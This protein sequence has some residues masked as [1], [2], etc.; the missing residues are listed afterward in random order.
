[1]GYNRIIAQLLLTLILLTFFSLLVAF[2]LVGHPSSCSEG[3]PA[4]PKHLAPLPPPGVGE[5]ARLAHIPALAVE[6]T[7][8]GQR[9]LQHF[10]TS[11]ACLL[12]LSWGG[13]S[14]YL[15]GWVMLHQSTIHVYPLAHLPAAPSTEVDGR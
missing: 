2:V 7:F 6:G 8:G 5:A 9:H 3:Q 14:G 10:T 1:M 15:V 11:P 12:T 13:G 4:T